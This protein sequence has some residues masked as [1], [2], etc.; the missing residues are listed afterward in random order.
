MNTNTP[1]TS[2]HHS[3]KNLQSNVWS[4]CKIYS[5]PPCITYVLHAINFSTTVAE[6]HKFL[7]SKCAREIGAVEQPTTLTYFLF[8][9]C[10]PSLSTLFP[11]IIDVGETSTQEC[12]NTRIRGVMGL[13]G[14]GRHHCCSHH[15][16]LP[17]GGQISQCPN[18]RL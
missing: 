18:H 10:L 17:D 11:V 4:S 14:L 6:F 1:H 2:L 3:G 13:G 9:V 16:L 8:H 12:C 5:C 7:L 15:L